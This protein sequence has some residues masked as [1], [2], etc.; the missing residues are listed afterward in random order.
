VREPGRL[1]RLLEQKF[2]QL[3]PGFGIET[4]LLGAAQTAPQAAEQGDIDGRAAQAGQLA[5]L[6]DRLGNR[7]GP[8]NVRRLQEQGSHLPER[9]WAQVPAFAPPADPPDEALDPPAE[10][11]ADVVPEQPR[12]LH[13]LPWPEPIE[14]VAPVPDHP[15]VM[16][17]R[18]PIQHRVT[19]AAGPERIGPEWWRAEPPAVP[20]APDPAEAT[21]A[22]IRDYYRVEDDTG[23]RFWLYREGLY[24]PGVTPRWF[25]HGFFG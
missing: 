16:F 4:L 1:Y 9:A 3:D 21:Q 25:L 15:P 10:T 24:R 22:P 23:A 20:T 18:G 13:L 8:G 2:D 6:I 11:A 7:L 12:P 19:A 14:V 17:R 5:D